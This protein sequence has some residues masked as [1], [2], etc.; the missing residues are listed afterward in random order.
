MTATPL[1]LSPAQL[2]AIVATTPDAATLDLLRMG[3]LSKRR[4][5]LIAVRRAATD[6]A[7]SDAFDLLGAIDASAPGVVN[8]VL[9]RPLVNVWAI[10]CLRTPAGGDAG[11]HLRFLDN[12]AA[13]AAIRAGLAFDLPLA[14]P[15]GAVHLPGLGTAHGLGAGEAVVRGGPNGAT[16]VGVDA[17]VRIGGDG[18]SPVT[19]LRLGTDPSWAVELEDQDPYRTCFG[20]PPVGLLDADAQRTV[21]ATLAGAWDIL[22]RDFPAYAGIIGATMRAVAPVVAADDRSAVSAASQLAYGM[23]AVCRRTR[24]RWPCCSSTSSS[25]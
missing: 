14:A 6:A 3:Q 17:T 11:G 13:A 9:G 7:V 15:H 4:L 12:I 5:L 20:L 23:V 24:R 10:E 1:T 16:V 25:T 21:A 18:W 8:Q 19:T 22:T 2:D